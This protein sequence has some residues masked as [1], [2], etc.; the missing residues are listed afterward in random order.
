[1]EPNIKFTDKKIKK[2]DQLEN[3]TNNALIRESSPENRNNLW[4]EKFVRKVLFSIT[5]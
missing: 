2:A 5:D 1:M 4:R 3:T